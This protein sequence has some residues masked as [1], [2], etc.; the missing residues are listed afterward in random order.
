M[1]WRAWLKTRGLF[2]TDPAAL[3][4]DASSETTGG[5]GQPGRPRGFTP[6]TPVSGRLWGLLPRGALLGARFHAEHAENAARKLPPRCHAPRLYRRADE[7][8]CSALFCTRRGS[9][10]IPR[11]AA[12]ALQCWASLRRLDARSRAGVAA[13]RCAACSRASRDAARLNALGPPTYNM[14]RRRR[15]RTCLESRSW[16]RRAPC[17]AAGS[18]GVAVHPRRA[19]VLNASVAA[20]LSPS[21]A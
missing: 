5:R 6:L 8:R 12:A 17:P 1:L 2:P 16:L 20:A 19:V 13:T 15:V 21:N 7:A 10:M 3:A 11:E 4:E 18:S 9:A 14:K